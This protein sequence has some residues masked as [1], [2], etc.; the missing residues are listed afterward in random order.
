MLSNKWT[1]SLTSFVVLI[2]FGL[3]YFAPSVFA[4]GDA[5]KT[6]HDLDVVIS[7]AESMIDVSDKAGLQIASGRHRN[8]RNF[9]LDGDGLSG[10]LTISTETGTL[11]DITADTDSDDVILLSVKFSHPVN[12]EVPGA[13]LEDIEEATIGREEVA[14][15]KPATADSGGNF[16]ADD[17]YAAAYDVEGRQLGV[18]P[19]NRI[20][21]K[22]SADF[23]DAASPGRNF[24]VNI[25]QHYLS[26]AYARA[27]DTVLGVLA[28]PGFEIST[29]VFFIPKGTS[30][31]TDANLVLGKDATVTRG[32]R[33][34]DFAHVISHFGPDA[35]Q[36]LNNPS[37]QFNVDLVDADQGNPRYNKGISEDGVT[38]A[39]VG[40]TDDD[41]TAYNASGSGTPGVVTIDQLNQRAGFIETGPF[42]VRII[43]TEEP[44]GGL[45]T[46]MIL[47]E[48]GGSATAVTKGVSLRGALPAIGEVDAVVQAVRDNELT[49]A[50]ATYY[51]VGTTG[52]PPVPDLQ[53]GEDAMLPE[54]T[55]RD[56]MYYQ[57]FVTIEPDPGVNGNLTISLAL[58]ED[59][60]IPTP[61]RYIPLT[62]EQRVAT[63]LSAAQKLV[64][65]T[66][67]LNETLM[68]TVAAGADTT[69][70]KALAT[71]VYKTR[72]N[73]DPKG[74]INL[75]P[76]L[77]AVT[78]KQV[79][80]AGGYL[81]L[82]SGADEA[83][84]GVKSV[85]AT[86]VG[87]LTQA[88]KDY[89]VVYGFKLPFPA[90]NLDSFFRNGGT[91]NLVYADIVAATGSGTDES[92]GPT[93]AADLT[94]YTVATTNAYAA[95]TV[96]ISEI[97]W[98]LDAGG[99]DS[100]YIELH[101][102]SATAAVA[103]DHLEWAISV[104]SGASTFHCH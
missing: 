16:G 5:E 59:N 41:A 45:T 67:A 73:D 23:I 37:N 103:I 65:D 2:A 88:Q 102:P 76:N 77:I 63:R 12:L 7:A 6:H 33:K 14:A 26:N 93:A 29:L 54:A 96:I 9:D 58:F 32:V 68:V 69:S 90:D 48:G 21:T 70:V 99:T 8:D 31:T 49:T 42:D 17:I 92:K 13:S 78:S 28:Q 51:N 46:D 82:A 81:V 55:G 1:F 30:G 91:I 27:A 38:G 39:T 95:G 84:S 98:G 57:Y 60:V 100:Q 20:A 72:L 61:N 89:N 56:N 53:A 18:L 80:P 75:N 79:I 10:E 40:G 104:G 11:G 71:A 15:G 34:A 22:I 36:H 101:N 62:A 25:H 43:L 86:T 35:H 66:R 87:K 52:T 74:I 50:I 85:A 64:R 83:T 19:L 3:V 97:M 4:D 24:L 44:K 47:V 94:G